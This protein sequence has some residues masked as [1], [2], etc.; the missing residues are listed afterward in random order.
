MPTKDKL[1]MSE[2][3][4]TGLAMYSGWCS[5]HGG[6][7]NGGSC[8]KCSSSDAIVPFE[9]KALILKCSEC[10]GDWYNSHVCS[11]REETMDNEQYIELKSTTDQRWTL[12]RDGIMAIRWQQ[13]AGPLLGARVFMYSGLEIPFVGKEAQRLKEWFNG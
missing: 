6:W 1:L 8:P 10:G 11:Q 13:E 3:D 9:K 2:T 4:L 12:E 7:Y 5:M